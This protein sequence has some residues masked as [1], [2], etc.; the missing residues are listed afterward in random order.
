M[1][2]IQTGYEWCLSEKVR[3]LNLIDWDTKM[4]DPEESFFEERIEY[5]EFFERIK[6]CK[7]KHNSLP[8]KTEGYL[9]YR[10]YGFVMYNL[11]DIQ[12]GIQ[13]GH[14][15]VE[16]TSLYSNTKSYK[17]WENKDKTFIILNGGSSNRSGYSEY[18]D[19]RHSTANFG[20]MEKYG[21]ELKDN[22]IPFAVFYEPD[23]NN[24]T[25]AI[26]FLVDERVFDRE[27]YPDFIRNEFASNEEND[28]QYQNWVEKIGGKA[29]EFLRGWLPKFKLA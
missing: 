16:Y 28:K 14:A 17:R 23:L 26:V 12:K 19:N 20:T 21:E 15:V 5:I 24:A 3:P 13:F 8:R 10:M 9:K 2:L 6:Q 29:N 7:V 11:S 22:K 1:S 27:L 4:V 18:D 25:S